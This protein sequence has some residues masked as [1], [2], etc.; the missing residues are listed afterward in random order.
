MKKFL[1]ICILALSLISSAAKAEMVAHIPEHPTSAL[2]IMHGLG[3]DAYSL[4]WMTKKLKD[5]LPDTAFYYPEAPDVGPFGGYQWFVIPHLGER[6]ADIEMYNEMMKDALKNVQLI[7]RLIDEIHQSQNIPYD[8]IY[9]SGF[10]Q[11]GL[12]AV[13]TGL[14]NPHNISKVISFSGVPILFTPDF[15]P[16]Q[17]ITAPDILLIQG[18]KDTVIPKDSLKM[19]AT[20]L[21]SVGI[22]PYIRVIQGMSHSINAQAGQY[23]VDFINDNLN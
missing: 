6:I 7:H 23:L 3:G 13:L 21:V 2:I 8:K 10:S 9:V 11:G 14:T 4:S 18:N 15:K 22:E 17:I 12:M 16:N 19:S 20:T 5:N 1:S